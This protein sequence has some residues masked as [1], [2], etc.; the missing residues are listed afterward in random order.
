MRAKEEARRRAHKRLQVSNSICV[1]FLK[2]ACFFVF[3]LLSD[4]G[5]PLSGWPGGGGGGAGDGRH[6]R[7]R[8]ERKNKILNSWGIEELYFIS[9]K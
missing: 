5:P 6:R 4:H 1:F 7:H 2:K 3:V 8:K 9:I